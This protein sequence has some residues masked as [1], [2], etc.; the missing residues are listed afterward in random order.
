MEK[1]IEQ[2]EIA[3]KFLQAIA[4]EQ[5]KKIKALQEEIDNLKKL[6]SG[7]CSIIDSLPEEDIEKLREAA[8]EEY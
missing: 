7:G 8:I 5:T 6:G 1:Q 2:L 3:N 4:E